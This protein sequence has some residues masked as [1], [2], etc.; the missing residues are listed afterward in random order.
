MINIL[1]RMMQ[2]ICVLFVFACMALWG[3]EWLYPSTES[4]KHA[5]SKAILLAGFF[6]TLTALIHV[7]LENKRLRG[8]N[9]A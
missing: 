1:L 3:Y 7:T 4:L 2:V 6:S 9:R 8:Q 5:A